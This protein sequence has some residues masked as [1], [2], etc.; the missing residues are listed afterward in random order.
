MSTFDKILSLYVVN[1][2]CDIIL[3]LSCHCDKIVSKVDNFLSIIDRFLSGVIKK[4]HPWQK[5]VNTPLQLFVR[6]VVNDQKLIIYYRTGKKLPYPTIAVTKIYRPMIK[7]CRPQ[8]S[9]KKINENFFYR[10]QKLGG[11]A[12][13]WP[14]TVG[15]HCKK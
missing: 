7:F 6:G 1:C 13:R 11:E 9:A 15:H 5:Y 3:S 14:H 10:N 8:N 2:H 12:V 4:Y